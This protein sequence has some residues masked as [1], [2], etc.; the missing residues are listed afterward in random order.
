MA[1]LDR[2]RKALEQGR[3]WLDRYRRRPIVDP[4]PYTADLVSATAFMLD[5][6][7]GVVTHLEE[8]E[9]PDHG[10]QLLK[11][12]RCDHDFGPA[13]TWGIAWKVCRLCGFQQ[14]RSIVRIPYAEGDSE[15]IDRQD[16]P[17]T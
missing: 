1:D 13:G 12:S 8:L 16:L 14:P 4:D 17:R 7:D 6:L 11:Q 5:A 9:S 2:V 10:E 15:L 3:V